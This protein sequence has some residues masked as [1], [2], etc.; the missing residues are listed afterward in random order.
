M[1]STRFQ[2]LLVLV[3]ISSCIFGCGEL[4]PETFPVSGI[5]SRNGKPV[6][7]ARVTLHPR[8]DTSMGSRPLGVTDNS[9]HFQLMS[10]T[11]NDGAPPGEYIVTVERRA[12]ADDGGELS[13][14][15]RHELP[16]KYSRPDTSPFSFTVKAEPNELPE[17]KLE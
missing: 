2:N 9:G 11:P 14:I 10:H 8:H 4:G 17:L 3:A 15:G 16:V 6:V 5:V 1:Y 7:D 13:R 12:M